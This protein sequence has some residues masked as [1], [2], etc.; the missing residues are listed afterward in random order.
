MN[1]E[2]VASARDRFP[3]SIDLI[4]GVILIIG[5]LAVFVNVLAVFYGIPTAFYIELAILCL[6]WITFLPHAKMQISE[7]NIRV[8][9]FYDK[10]SERAQ[11]IWHKI[12]RLI[13]DFTRIMIV[14]SVLVAITSFWGT[15]TSGAGI[16]VP[17]LYA[18]LGI[19]LAFIT[20]IEFKET[21][22]T[23]IQE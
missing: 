1:L 5:T 14:V 2:L 11:S 13:V 3:V 7:R 17:L 18:P 20:I 23:W 12:V 9:Y 8:E 19:A 6:M 15:T 16:P 21:I 22:N 4:S 10:L